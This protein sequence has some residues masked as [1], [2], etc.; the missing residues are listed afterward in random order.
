MNRPADE[1]FWNLQD[2]HNAC[3]VAKEGSAEAL[4]SLTHL[5]TEE[6]DNRVVLLGKSGAA[7]QFTHY[8][9][10]QLCQT[11]GAPASYLRKKDPKVVASCL[12][13]DI[14]RAARN[15]ALTDRNILFWK[16][17][18]LIAR[19]ITSERYDRVWDS[20]IC[21][22]LKQLTDNG[23]RVPA[24][25]MPPGYDG[26]TKTATTEDILPGQ[27]NIHEGNK[28]AP[29]GLYASDHDMFAFLVAPDRVLSDGNGGTLMRGVFISNSEVGDGALALKFFL[30]QAVCGNHIVWN[31][32]GVHEINV[33]HIGKD[34][35]HR[36]FG[37][38]RAT[39]KRYHDAAPEEESKILAARNC[40]LGQTKSEVLDAVMKYAK[41]HSLQVIGRKLAEEAYNLADAHT[42]WYGSPRSVWGM[43]AG[44]TQLSQTTG[45]TDERHQ[46]DKAAGKILEMAF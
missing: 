42:D 12:N 22:A 8:A 18:D 2:M 40:I 38:F 5:H 9:F 32:T 21:H 30:M 34:T 26:P 28:I 39:L 45:Y 41:T 17:G 19:A 1:R 23:W 31:A 16:N 43:T 24:G 44:F 3:L 29:S 27:I 10:G 33:R 11:I 25:R 14:Q 46:L 6:K 20:D 15:E 37:N 4:V 36:A 7:A 13:E 35:F